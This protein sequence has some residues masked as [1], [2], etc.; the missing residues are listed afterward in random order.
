MKVQPGVCGCNV[1]EQDSDG[2]S[3]PNCQDAC[4]ADSQ[5]TTPGLCGCGTSEI[6]S[7]LDLAP[8]CIDQCPNDSL[9][10]SPGTCGCGIPETDPAN[11]GSINCVDLCPS[12]P[13]KGSPGV[14][15]CGAADVDL[16]ANGV[17]DCKLNSELRARIQTA[18]G[19]LSKIKIGANGKLTKVARSAKASLHAA[20]LEMSSFI[21]NSGG[22][23]ILVNQS[24]DIVAAFADAK[25]KATTVMKAR[26]TLQNDKKKAKKA[27]S[28]LNAALSPDN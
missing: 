4:P 21:S 25:R 8:N 2:D 12:N 18:L 16:N 13:Q 17:F 20:L 10:V 26:S 28:K 3:T 24:T 5:K 1:S 22:S 27:F 15:G 7:D 23:F 11:N 6:D 9:K 14:C 19:F